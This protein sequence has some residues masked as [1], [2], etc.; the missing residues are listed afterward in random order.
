MDNIHENIRNSFLSMFPFSKKVTPIESAASSG[1]P[2]TANNSLEKVS[3]TDLMIIAVNVKC[4]CSKLGGS[5]KNEN[6]ILGQYFTV[7][8]PKMF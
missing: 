6:V 2:T 3:R 7:C 8:F 1:T 5:E 4:H